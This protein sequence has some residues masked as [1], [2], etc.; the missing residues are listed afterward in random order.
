MQENEV[1][2]EQLLRRLRLTPEQR[3]LK[4]G[5]P[6]GKKRD[7]VI[8]IASPGTFAR[9]ASGETKSAGKTQAKPGRKRK[10]DE[11]RELIGRARECPMARAIPRLAGLHPP[12]QMPFSRRADP[13][14]LV[15][16]EKQSQ[17]RTI[18]LGFPIGGPGD[19]LIGREKCQLHIVRSGR[20]GLEHLGPER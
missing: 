11:I 8:A 13:I 10:A 1:R 17:R 2:H 19:E 5:K 18:T 15:S 12:G 4:H 20:S 14:E 16:M 9:W 7:E 3:R 6:L